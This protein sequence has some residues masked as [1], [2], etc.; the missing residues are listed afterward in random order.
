MSTC[1]LVKPHKVDQHSS[2]NTKVDQHPQPIEATSQAY[3]ETMG[4]VESLRV[5]E[6]TDNQIAY[7]LLARF[8]TGVCDT[9]SEYTLFALWCAIDTELVRRKSPELL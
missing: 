6:C 7:I 9:I 3:R 1:A 8:Q 4:F 5:L 2:A